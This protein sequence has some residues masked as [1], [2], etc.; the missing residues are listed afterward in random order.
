MQVALAVLGVASVAVG[1]RLM[2]QATLA[3]W[4]YVVE[5]MREG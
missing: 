3:A 2:W 4:R 5:R 1:L